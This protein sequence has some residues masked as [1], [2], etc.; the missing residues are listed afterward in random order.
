MCQKSI[1]TWILLYFV[2]LL[3]LCYRE[4]WTH[5]LYVCLSS[6]TVTKHQENTQIVSFF[7]FVWEEWKD[8]GGM[9]TWEKNVLFVNMC[10]YYYHSVFN[11]R[12]IVWSSRSHL[13]RKLPVL[14]G[15][16]FK[17]T[18]TL[19][20]QLLT[21]QI[22]RGLEKMFIPRRWWF[23]IPC[24][25]EAR[26]PQSGHHCLLSPGNSRTVP[27][28]ALCS[29]CWLKLHKHEDLSFAKPLA[30]DH[31]LPT[32]NLPH[33]PHSQHQSQTAVIHKNKFSNVTFL[34]SPC[35]WM[36]RV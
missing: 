14:W 7:T 31:H 34:S 30:W 6:Y 9:H 27:L 18:H 32:V 8:G 21:T 4:I 19:I 36:F 28:E 22:W 24:C 5:S 1:I 29:L 12:E 17:E 20:D 15:D 25:W 3:L 33:H 16:I 26:F 13:K 10:I 23:R 2:L 11:L 35:G